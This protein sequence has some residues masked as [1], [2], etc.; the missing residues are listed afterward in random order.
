MEHTV[1]DSSPSYAHLYVREET[2]VIT[3]QHLILAVIIKQC[4]YRCSKCMEMY[5][6][7]CSVHFEFQ[8]GHTLLSEP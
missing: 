5:L 6:P 3:E 1:L 7:G 2:L 4:M 8:I